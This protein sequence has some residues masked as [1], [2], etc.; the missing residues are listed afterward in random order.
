MANNRK[1]GEAMKRIL[2]EITKAG[3]IDCDEEKIPQGYKI[4]IRDRALLTRRD[5]DPEDVEFIDSIF[6]APQSAKRKRKRKGLGYYVSPCKK[7]KPTRQEWL[8]QK[9]F[10]VPKSLK[11]KDWAENPSFNHQAYCE[12]FGFYDY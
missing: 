2:I 4:V 9:V 1:G 12:K 11:A 3:C 8:N 6:Q 10:H 7:N 5:Y